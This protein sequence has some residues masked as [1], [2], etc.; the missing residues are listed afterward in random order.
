[1]HLGRE[2]GRRRIE[3][4]DHLINHRFSWL[5]GSQA[6][7]LTAFVLLRNDPRFYEVPQPMTEAF[8]MY[9]HQTD[10]LVYFVAVAGLIFS[11]CSTI[12][13]YAAHAAIQA[14]RTKVKADEQVHLTADFLHILFGG[15]ASFLPGP[16]LA[17]I[18]VL[19]LVEEWK[20]FRITLIELWCPIAVGLVT[21][22]VWIA[23]NWWNF[24][25]GLN[26]A[27]TPSSLSGLKSFQE[28][29]DVS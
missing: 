15:V 3:Q 1:M 9:Q 27:K 14:W 24:D 13:V 12:G 6:F 18:W 28:A 25:S 7:L 19:L 4:E 5:V 26:G 11:V 17:S 29:N 2:D 22:A 10:L 21:F 20:T 8:K 23:I 16:V